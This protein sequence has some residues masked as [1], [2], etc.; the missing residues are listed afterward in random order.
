MRREPLHC[1]REITNQRFNK[2]IYPN[3]V[4]WTRRK[5]ASVLVV[6]RSAGET[7]C[8]TSLDTKTI[9]NSE[10][11]T[12]LGDFYRLIQVP[13]VACGEP[14]V[15]TPQ[16]PTALVPHGAHTKHKNRHVHKSIHPMTLR[17]AKRTRPDQA[18]LPHPSWRTT[19]AKTK[20]LL[21]RTAHSVQNVFLEHLQCP[22]LEH[23]QP[24]LKP[25][26]L[27]SSVP[28]A[29]KSRNPEHPALPSAHA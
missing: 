27:V 1:K 3:V 23:A 8:T 9:K 20:A 4:V 12:P 7:G 24:R 17:R 28:V 29:T 26:H 16:Q 19:P 15:P 13:I 6:F 14:T 18:D 21:Q 5:Q 2:N 11:I 10:R 22:L 25:P